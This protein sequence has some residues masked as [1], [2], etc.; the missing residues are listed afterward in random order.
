MMN[1]IKDMH[2]FCLIDNLHKFKIFFEKLGIIFGTKG[3]KTKLCY[4][5]ACYTR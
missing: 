1:L 5:V 4:N 2:T 3:A